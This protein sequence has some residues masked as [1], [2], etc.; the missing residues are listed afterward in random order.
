MDSSKG[1]LVILIIGIFAALSSFHH[2][3]AAE[4][5]KR[6]SWVFISLLVLSIVTE[7]VTQGLQYDNAV[8]TRHEQDRRITEALYTMNEPNEQLALKVADPARSDYEAFIIGYWYFKRGDYDLAKIYLNLAIHS[9]RFVPQSY[10]LL[11]TIN[12]MTQSNNWTEAREDYNMAI[13]EDR[14]YGP[15]YYGRAILSQASN[16]LGGALDDLEQAT[17]YG[18]GQCWDVRN[19]NEQNTVWQ[20]IKDSSKYRQIEDE[21]G[22]RFGLLQH[23]GS[24][25]SK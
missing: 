14:E 16:D 18:I 11:A 7:L 4:G 10:Y 9:Q 21:C 1:E 12:R 22:A 19:P 24:S 15:P 20:K 2:Y 5:E 13:K 6:K 25:T 8:L 23:A 17:T 3:F